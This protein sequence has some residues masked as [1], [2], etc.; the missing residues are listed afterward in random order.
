MRVSQ[1]G[2]TLVELLIGTALLVG[3]GGALA[4][5]MCASMRHADYL[6]QLEV[7]TNAA[8]GKLEQLM[9]T[10]FDTLWN[11]SCP[12]APPVAPFRDACRVPPG[13]NGQCTGL[14]EDFNCD[15]VLNA[16]EDLNNNGVLNEPLAGARLTVQIRSADT[17]TPANPDL[18]D[19]HVALC[20]PTRF[21]TFGEDDNCNGVMDAGEDANGNGWMDAP[22]MFSARVARRG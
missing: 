19:L 14:G 10:P 22:V 3:G 8:Q 16:G 7:A 6:S 18:L 4:V 17:R 1:H 12:A 21:G 20:W 15:G 2:F 5:G 11:S 13:A 9:A